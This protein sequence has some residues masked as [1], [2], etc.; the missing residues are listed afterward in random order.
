MKKIMVFLLGT[1]TFLSCMSCFISTN[2]C[3]TSSLSYVYVGGSGPGNYSSIS[4]A[5][6]NI[7]YGGTIFVYAGTYYE[8]IVID[9]PVHLIGEHKITNILDGSGEGYVVILQAGNSS[10]EGFTITHSG[11]VFPNAGV[12]IQSDNNKIQGNIFSDNFYGLRLDPA[13]YTLLSGN[14]IQYNKKCG[15][16]FS[17]S[18]HN[19]LIANI[20]SH[21][22][23]NGF[24][25]YEFS[26]N[27]TLQDNILSFNNY[28]GINIRE[29]VNNK[30]IDNHLLQ[31]RR[32]LHIPSPEYATV[33]RGNTISGNGI[34][35][36]EEKN[37][38]VMVGVV[39]AVFLLIFYAVV[40]KLRI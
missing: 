12:W 14:E 19:T 36:D 17:G 23:F 22:P 9:K 35:L 26:N 27:N 32:G 37:P 10:L 15:V 21:Q 40:R 2:P 39:N 38:I 6:Q 30:V 16:Y 1:L 28:S 4:D 7:T 18:S 29:S 34:N 11:T 24:G 33:V 25:L 31:N 3:L 5:L 8:H 13:N 20:V